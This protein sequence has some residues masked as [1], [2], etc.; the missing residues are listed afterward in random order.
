MRLHFH[1]KV[2][3]T[4]HIII[5]ISKRFKRKTVLRRDTF[6]FN[7]QIKM[8]KNPILNGPWYIKSPCSRGY[9]I[10]QHSRPE[11]LL[12]ARERRHFHTYTFKSSLHNHTH[13]KNLK[14]Y[15]Q[16]ILAYLYTKPKPKKKPPTYMNL[17]HA[18]GRASKSLDGK[19]AEHFI[20]KLFVLEF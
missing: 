14:Q 10:K 7:R 6:R 18:A 16:N 9:K 13:F 3:T 12:R 19:K 4:H 5:Y 2:Q 8:L 20:Y 15:S 17:I 11:V 1:A